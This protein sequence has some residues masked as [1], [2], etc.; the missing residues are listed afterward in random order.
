MFVFLF[1]IRFYSIAS[2]S[3]FLDLSITK[4]QG[5]TALPLDLLLTVVE[6]QTVSGKQK[7]GFC[8]NYLAESKLGT[9]IALYIRS[10][11]SFH[12]SPAPKTALNASGPAGPSQG[13][14]MLL[15]GAGSGLAPFRG[16]WQQILVETGKKPGRCLDK[17][18]KEYKKTWVFLDLDSFDNLKQK[19]QTKP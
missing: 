7:K 8:S 1:P 6:Y 12:M 16:F 17:T 3:E 5:Q 10:T 4:S 15:V 14:P 9:E 2:S 11:P 19:P 13:K 18:I